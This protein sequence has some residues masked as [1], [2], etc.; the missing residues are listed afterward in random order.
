M[1]ALLAFATRR[2]H[3]LV[4]LV[5]AMMALAPSLSAQT[6]V[7][8]GKVTTVEG[9]PLPGVRVTATSL[10]GNVTREARTDQRGAFQIVFPGG[11]GDYIMGYALIG[12]VFRQFEIKRMVDED[13]LIADA[14]LSVIQLDT[15]SVTASVQQRVNRNQG[16]PDVSGTEQAIASMNLPPELMGDIAAMAA[17]LPGVMLVPGLDGA[18]DGFSVMGLGADQN[19]VTLNGQQLG[20][21]GLPRDALVSSSLSTSPFDPSRGGFSGANFN[22]R[23]ATGSNFKSRGMSLVVNTPQLEWTDQ[24]ARALG[25]EYTNVSVGGL[26]SGPIQ[27]NKSFYNVSYQFGRRSSDNQTLLNAGPLGLRTAGVAQ[28]SVT[29]FMTILNNGGLSSAAGSLRPSKISDNGSVS[30]SFDL[31]PPSSTSGS[32]YGLTFNGNWGRQNAVGSGATQLSSATGDRTNW[33]GAIQ[34][35]HGGYFGMILTESNLGVSVSRDYGDPYLDLPSGRVRVNSLFDGGASGVQMLSFGGNQSLSSSSRSVTSNFQNSL[36]WFD[37]GNKH[38]IKLSTELSHVRNTQDLSSNLLGTFTFNSLED[39]EAGRPAFFSRTLTARQRSTGQIGGAMSL[40]DYYRRSPDLQLN[41]GLRLETSRFTTTPTFNPAIEAAFQRRNDHLPTPITLSPRLGFSYT[42][43]TA[44]EINPFVGAA[45]APRAVIRGGIGMFANTANPGQIG[46]A[47]DNTGLP[48]GSQQIMCVGD[49]APTPKWGDYASNPSSVPVQC[50]DGTTG[51]VFANASPNVYLV[52][53]AFRPQR[54]IRSNLSWSGSILD[55][56]FSANVDGSYSV[57]LNQQRTVD[58]NFNRQLQFNLADDSRPVYVQTSSI[59]PTTGIIASSD[60]RVS[61]SFARVS[62]LRSDLRSNTAQLSFRLSPITRTINTF[63]WSAAYTYTRIR[64]QVSGFSS[65][66]GDPLAIEW[67]T[68]GQGPH[69]FNYNFRYTFM[70]AVQVN[71]TGTFRSGSAFTPMIAGDVNGDGYSN[72]RAFVFSPTATGV[73]PTMAAGM[74]SLLASATGATRTCLEKQL[75]HIAARNS[76]R[77]P[78]SSSASLNVSLDRVKFRMPQRAQLSFSLLNPLGAADLALHGSNKLRG[79]G[80][81]P[82]PDQ[83][84]LYVRGFDPQNRKYT[85]EVNQRFGA[86][87]PQFLTLRS[88]VTLTASMRFDLGAMR[89]RQSL[90]Q[91]LD[92]GRHT[93][94]SRYPEQLF[95]SAGANAVMNPMGAILR[96]QDS[97]RLTSTQADSIASMNRRYAYRSDSVWAPVSRYFAGLPANYQEDEAYDRYLAARRAQV[98]LLATIGPSVRDL[99]TPEQRRKL[100]PVVLNSLDTRYLSSIRNGTGLYVSGNGFGTPF[101]IAG[102]GM[103]MSFGLA[104]QVM[105]MS[106][107]R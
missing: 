72:D 42:L 11:P 96:Q 62:E 86:T 99:L 94:G 75:G 49:A 88:P 84:L 26:V 92:F 10:P 85:Y 48:S 63:T 6:D 19:S 2:R 98:D 68:A 39:L 107:M 14:K 58:I 59:V 51:T 70:N 1:R 73:D 74:Q 79:W 102:G 93:P 41:Y 103:G 33:G 12:Y 91:Q 30:G 15:V 4:A 37:N 106:V 20:T 55:A 23:T 71:W 69:S 5:P 67:A 3:F 95:R 38:R 36:S 47:L 90:I 22:I 81:T 101:G 78:W 25:A 43:G 97:L 16:T 32:S 35:R 89:E 45:R 57:N 105:V 29:R 21:N 50:A 56:R 54:T 28:D 34:A 13:V 46:A 65:T 76:C 40:G 83:S 52:S 66:A 104:E 100:P 7:I 82:F 18:P 87:R 60:A 77:G 8:R 24:A 53:N 27:R 17:S 80:Q 44:P 9:L 64:E 31:S 61:Q